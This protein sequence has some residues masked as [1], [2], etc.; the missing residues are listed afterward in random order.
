MSDITLNEQLE[1]VKR[2]VG[3][4]AHLYPRWVVNGKMSQQKADRELA[5]MRAVQA[6]LEAQLALEQP[7]L[8]K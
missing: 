2:E 1:C 3:M 4:R 5:L 6:T 7:G 8:F